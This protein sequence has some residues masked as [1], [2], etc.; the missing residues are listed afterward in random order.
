MN[1]TQEAREAAAEEARKL[2][3]RYALY[4]KV[5]I[6]KVLL[7]YRDSALNGGIPKV[8]GPHY[9]LAGMF[10][11][12]ASYIAAAEARGF[13]RAREMAAKV[14]DVRANNADALAYMALL[15]IVQAL[16]DAIRAMEDDQS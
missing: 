12:A 7:E 2:R 3:E 10:E 13:E 11:W 15:A 6:V 16:P 9:A 8:L 1:I 14:A 4:D 5:D